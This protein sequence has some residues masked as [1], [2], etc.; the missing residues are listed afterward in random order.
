MMKAVVYRSYGAPGLV[1]IEQLE[2]PVPKERELLIKVQASA[3]NSADVR[4]RKAAPFAVRFVYGLFA[5]KK[6]VLGVVFSGIVESAGKKV[7]RF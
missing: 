1:R 4:L 6:P 3:V 2:K 7:T 5:P